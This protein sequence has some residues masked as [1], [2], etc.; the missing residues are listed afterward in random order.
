VHFGV[1]PQLLQLHCSSL[2]MKLMEQAGVPEVS[3]V[4]L[5]VLLEPDEA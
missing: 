3:V 5:K 2:P 1:L 4:E